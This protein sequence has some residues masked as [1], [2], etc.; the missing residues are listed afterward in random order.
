MVRLLIAEDERIIREGIEESLPWKELGV[1]EVQS[2]SSGEEAMHLA[3][4]FKPDIVISDIRMRGMTGVELCSHLREVSKD[5][6]IIFMSGYADKE[7]LLSAIKLQ[8][9]EY[10]EKPVSL[11]DLCEA[12]KKACATVHKIQ[13]QQQKNNSPTQA[14]LAVS[15][16]QNG[17]EL[18][19]MVHHIAHYVDT[20]YTKSDLS[21]QEIADDAQL[22]AA[23]AGSLFKSETGITLKDYI[24]EC[25]LAKAKSLL[26]DPR[27]KVYEIAAMTGWTDAHYF[28]RMFR[29]KTGLKPSEYREQLASSA[30]EI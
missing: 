17:K 22:T 6:Q 19:S 29:D 11:S 28:A 14:K 3:L 15:P 9:L 18:S 20:H 25:R 16:N 13:E 12:V 8:A 2:V 4:S 26:K 30:S 5:L 7:Y 10:L 1:D 21:V 27:Y 24:I 23:Y